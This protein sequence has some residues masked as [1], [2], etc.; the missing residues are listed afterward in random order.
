[1]STGTRVGFVL[2]SPS[3]QPI[4]S[5]RVAVLNMLPLLRAAGWQADILHDPTHATETPTLPL[6]A[7]DIVAAG[8]R[9]VVFQKVRGTDVTRL[10]RALA[11][12]GVRTVYLVCDIVDTEMATLCDA[13]VVVTD[14]LRS[15]YP[16]ALRH[17]VHVVHDGIERPGR[18][19]ASRRD[20][21]G[22]AQRPLRA[23]LVSSARLARLPVI[24]R[25]PRWLE[26]RVVGRYAKHPSRWHAWR[27]VQWHVRHAGGPAAMW[28]ALQFALDDRVRCIPWTADGVYDELADADIGILPIDTQDQPADGRPPDWKVKSENRLTL[29]MAM[30]LPVVATPIPAYE[31]VIRHG[32]DGFIANSPAQWLEILDSL[33]DP[34]LRRTVGEAARPAVLHRF[35]MQHQCE[36]LGS[37]FNQLVQRAPA[38]G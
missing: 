3:A 29:K 28:G 6:A 36:R 26:V 24:E 2:L 32:Q 5:T 34:A 35:S 12:C 20:D 22:S 8:Y 1:M 15:L 9:V 38:P 33:R 21:R 37:V 23:V 27:D 7:A 4:P 10:A 30:G 25:P 31:P 14:Y 16:P 17:K 19:V 18:Q 13:T 11:V